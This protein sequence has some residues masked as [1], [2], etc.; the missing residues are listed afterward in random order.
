[1]TGVNKYLHRAPFPRVTGVNKYLH[2]APFPRYYLIYSVRD[3][4]WPWE[5]LHYRKYSWI[6]I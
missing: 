1:V 4:L 5:V 6:I 3:C 2:R